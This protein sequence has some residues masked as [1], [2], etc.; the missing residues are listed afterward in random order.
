MKF[1]KPILVIPL[2]IL[3][4]HQQNLNAQS[5]TTLYEMQD[6]ISLILNKPTRIIDPTKTT[7]MAAAFPGLGQVYNRKYWKIP[8]VYA[9]FGALG[10]SIIRN[11]QY[12]DEFIEAY[13]DLNDD[14]AETN[15][16]EKY[17][18]ATY[19]S[20]EIDPALG[21]DIYNPVSNSWVKDWLL[22]RISF[23][24]KYRDLSYIGVAV[25]YIVSILDANVDAV[26]YDY[27]VSPDL[28]VRFE[29]TPIYFVYG[30]TIGL[31]ITVTF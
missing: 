15:S 18:I 27:D 12:F 22:N 6:S 21:A 26:L 3:I 19:D 24:R 8:L 1:I 30:K 11:S 10:Y 23:Y 5:D 4:T 20:E 13:Q 7:L 16:Y 31:S 2:L 25:W 28:N 14:V 17:T 29:P 9:G